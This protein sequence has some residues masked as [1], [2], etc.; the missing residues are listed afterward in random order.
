[1]PKNKRQKYQR[2]KS[3]PNVTVTERDSYPP[4]EVFPWYENRYDGMRRVLEL[5]CG[6]GEHSLA[7][8]AANSNTLFVGVDRKSHRICVGAETAIA[9]GLENVQ[10]LRA[11]I[12][13][14][15]TFFTK[16][17]IDEIWL[18]F[19]DPHPKLRT[20][21]L[22]LSAPAFLDTYAQLLMPGGKVHLKTDSDLLFDYTCES[23]DRWG[24]RVVVA[25]DN[26]HVLDNDRMG[27]RE[28][29]SAFEHAARSQGETIK[30]LAFELT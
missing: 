9:L 21:H 20:S 17:S 5:G 23:V 24:G 18:T 27:A 29:V 22:R 2:V 25:S 26:L 16:Q 3:L 6:K 13:M 11:R 15:E 28:V 30:Y 14:I 10:F 4:S 1:M 7:F 8:A 19:P 12:E